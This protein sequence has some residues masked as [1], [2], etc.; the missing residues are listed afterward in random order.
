MGMRGPA[1]RQAEDLLNSVIDTPVAL[2]L[3]AVIERAKAATG[4]AANTADSAAAAA[5]RALGVLVHSPAAKGTSAAVMEHFPL[6]Q[7][8]STKSLSRQADKGDKGDKGD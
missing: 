8:L 7:L 6:A 4:T 2:R 1:L 5:L 3:C